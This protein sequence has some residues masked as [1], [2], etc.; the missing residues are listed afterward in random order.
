MY[1]KLFI[2]SAIALVV[3]F[4]FTIC[5]ANEDLNNA[6]DGVRNIV[7]NAENTLEDAAKGVSNASKNMTEDMQHGANNIGNA[8]NEGMNNA[9]NAINDGVNRM[10]NAMTSDNNY[11]ATR[12][13]TT[14]DNTFMGM[15]STAWTWLIIGIAAVAIIALVWYYMAQLRSSDYH[16]KD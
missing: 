1:K 7:G 8:I 5:F 12:T 10:E 16:N 2:S 6:A 9:G 13:S 4:S 3:I 14:A 11:N 15:N